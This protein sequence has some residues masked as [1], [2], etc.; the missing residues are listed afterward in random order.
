MKYLCICFTADPLEEYRFVIQEDSIKNFIFIGGSVN[1]SENTLNHN[2]YE[3]DP[4]DSVFINLKTI[5]ENIKNQNFANQNI[6]GY[7][8]NY[9]ECTIRPLYKFLATI[10]SVFKSQGTKDLT[11]LVKTL[12]KWLGRNTYYYL[13][14]HESH[15]KLLYDQ[16]VNYCHLARDYAILENLK[17]KF[18]KKKIYLTGIK[19]ILRLYLVMG[20]RFLKTVLICTKFLRKN[21]NKL[22]I[23]SYD[24]IVISRSTSQISSVRDYLIKSDKK[25]LILTGKTFYDNG[26]NLALIKKIS[27]ESKLIDYIE[28]NNS[29]KD[30]LYF[31]IRGF[32][33]VLN[34]PYIN[35]KLNGVNLNLRQSLR[36]V[37]VMMPEIDLYERSIN[38]CFKHFSVEQEKPVLLSLE[39]KSPHA[40]I[41]SK[42]SKIHNLKC[43]HVM[44]CDQEIIKLPNPVFGDYFLCDSMP[45]AIKF[46][47]LYKNIESKKFSYVGTFKATKY[48]DIRQEA[49]TK[50]NKKVVCYFTGA[51]SANKNIGILRKLISREESG[52]FKL[53]VKLHPRDEFSTY[54]N[55][56]LK[57][58]NQISVDQS[59]ILNS[60]D[61]AVTSPSGVVLDLLYM[62]V[63]FCIIG[64]DNKLSNEIYSYWN[65]NFKNC[66]MT[67]DQLHEYLVNSDDYK[68]DFNNYLTEYK[69][70]CNP[71]SDITTIKNSIE[72]LKNI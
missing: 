16:E 42:I 35:F 3:G 2:H 51:E 72:L 48:N 23:N 32:F 14:E 41:D 9:Y 4:K 56:H 12:P 47:N 34:T 5:F 68:D 54:E 61:L 66:I 53:I 17:I 11:I 44:Q 63:Q 26:E 55:L 31:Y 25:V 8:N 60:Y 50:H 58:V 71:I 19:N 65:N 40:Y 67:E 46:K 13:A 28:L 38:E 45:T 22:N 36:E 24:Y 49:L 69:K 37:K 62:G 57:F 70:Y 33:N 39:Q 10:D 1:P 18:I 30:V 64:Y 59:M 6:S 43:M 27:S 29:L 7:I 20:L 52:Y 21:K 15:S